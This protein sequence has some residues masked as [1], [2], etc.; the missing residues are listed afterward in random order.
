MTNITSVI[1]ATTLAA[2]LM[3]TAAP[4]TRAAEP[5]FA[6]TGLA[7]DAQRYE[8]QIKV[9]IKTAKKSP[10]EHTADAVKAMAGPAADPRAAIASY[11]QTVIA[12]PTDADAWTGLALALL[13]IKPDTFVNS[14][15]SE[16]PLNASAA[17][18]IGYERAK[19]PAQKAQALVVLHEALKRRQLWRP[20]IEALKISLTLKDD[21]AVRAS[22][23]TLIAEKGFRLLDYKTDAD[24]AQPR[25]CMQFSE[26]LATGQIEF[27]KFVGV[28]GKAPQSVSVEGRQLCLDGLAHGKR[29]QVQV[30]QGLPS[31]VEE[32]LLKSSDLTVYVRD[33]NPS[34]RATGRAY[35]LPR[36]GQQGLP[37]VSVN[38]DAL[39]VEVYRVGD[40]G[41]AQQLQDGDFQRRL[42]NADIDSLKEK[43]GA[44]V[45][46]GEMAVTRKLNEDVTTAFP[47]AEAIGAL[48][49]GAYVLAAHVLPKKSDDNNHQ[50]IQW[51]IVSDLGLTVFSGDDGVHGFVRS[52]A[53]AG[54]VAGATIKLVARNNEILGT[55]KTDGNGY[56]RFDAGLKRGEGGLAPAMLTAESTD[57]DYAFLDL[58]TGAF[59][60]TDR[61]VKGRE[62][63]GPVDAY[64][65]AERGVYR[66]GETV[67]LTTLVR[68][69][70][71]KAATLPVTAIVTRPDGVEHRRSTL[72]DQG[73]G[74]RTQSLQLAAQAMSGTWRVKIH[75]DVKADRVAEVAF[76]VEDFLP[77]R[78]DLTLSAPTPRLT[79]DAPASIDIAGRYLYGPPAA[80][81]A[82][83]G[84]IVVK[85]STRDLEGLAGYRFGLVDEKINPVRK[86]LEELPV[87]GKDGKAKLAITLPPIDKTARSLEADVLIRLRESGGRTIERTLT[88][89]VDLKQ[90]RIGIKPLFANGVIAEGDNATF[91]VVL[92]GGDGK[93]VA[94]KNLK[95]ELLRIDQRYQWFNRDGE[96]TYDVQNSSR[97]I[98]SGSVDA[99]A[100]APGRIATRV[101]WGRYR[102]EVSSADGQGTISSTA[103][104][105]GFWAEEAADSPE[106]LDVALDKASYKPGDVARVK[107]TSRMAGKAMVAV[108]SAGLQ[109]IKEIDV[110]AG[111]AEFTVPVSDT[112]G[113]GAYVTVTLYRPMDTE[114]KRM[115]GRA[116]GLK[117]IGVEQDARTLKVALAIPDKVGSG[118]DVKVPVGIAGLKAGEQA[119]VV[120]TAVDVGILNLT[121]FEAPKPEGWFY[122][123]RRLAFEI[124]DFYSRLIDG[125]RAERGKLRSG[126]DG[127]AA[128]MSMSGS[129]PVDAIVSL[130]SGIVTVGAD[131]KADVAFKLPDFNGTV[132]ISAVAWS[133]DRVG[134]TTKDLLV[135]DTVALTV[136]GPRFLTLGDEARLQLD[137]HNIEG[138]AAPYKL[139]VSRL[140]DGR[141]LQ[142]KSLDLKA[143]EKKADT[144]TLKPDDVGRMELAV[145]VTGPGGIAV[146]R[147]LS[148]EVKPP[149]GDIKRVTVSSLK[150]KGGKLTLS[151]DL[152][153]DLIPS[154]TKVTLN[155]GPTAGLD[156][157]G[158]M[159]E[160]D[161]YPYGC[162]EQTT[163]RA[164]PLVYLNDVAKQIGIAGDTEIR[165]RVQKAVERVLEM[166][167][168]SGAFGIWGPA[169]GDIWLT[170]YVTDFLTRA[171][172]AKYTVAPRAYAQ[173]LDR[174]ANFV[175]IAQD[176]E[177]GGETR[178]YALYVLARAGRAPMADLRYDVDTRLERFATP[179]AQAQL[180]AALAQ[181]GDKARAEKAFAA[182][183]KAFDGKDNGLTRRDYGS[184]LRDGAAIVTLAA[185]S[186][187]VTSEVPRLVDV[188]AKAYAS[189]TYTS[190]QEQA[191]MLLAA[192]A[193]ADQAGDTTLSVN[194][195]S[196][197]GQLL[198]AMKGAELRDGQLT[199]VNDGDAPVNAFVAVFGAALTPEPAISKGF[200]IERSYFTLDGKKVDLASAA[201]GKSTL[202]QNDRLVVV[203]K[204]DTKETGGRILLVDR[205]P[206]G[207][208]IENPR[209][210]DSGEVKTLDWLKTTV[211]PEHTDFRD[212]RFVAAFDFFG[213]ENG[214]RRRGGDDEAKPAASSAT[215]AYIVRAVT[216]GSFIHPAATVEDMYRPER[217]AR[218]A[219]GRLDV[220]GK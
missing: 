87:T 18:W 106:M 34:V 22:Y 84:E 161:R 185:E 190:T 30:R 9:A 47:V 29:Y 86:P 136:S 15:R 219:A 73:Q 72:A 95:W 58:A 187:A 130:Y 216:P 105:A 132:R 199:I 53:T 19:A 104:N 191:W 67:N 168:A 68:D 12:A 66:P 213:S 176:F 211:A 186:R 214:R 17:A 83:E 142:A 10:R 189:R 46:S 209:L 112:W 25:L 45:Y 162:A 200:T 129:P 184:G 124:R 102:L 11:S 82:I 157:A 137:V 169:D 1:R 208:E 171:R 128:G 49:P 64:I 7:K 35:V 70:A 91:D 215:V 79:V 94:A 159:A 74:G 125:M 60:L 48:K 4:V 98:G 23:D 71:G 85:P 100:G 108:L 165:E 62:A 122:G 193:L 120:L 31:A 8:T 89:P 179:L 52:L 78:L 192:K 99:D 16:V 145:S 127:S 69:R 80:D 163:S 50:A 5:N 178:A 198:R 188:V 33:R 44:K 75:T 166:Q 210:V 217:H 77:E 151:P 160:L 111:G 96:W 59:D 172:E 37:V 13:A 32:G 175:A 88:L 156:I 150:P 153:A 42:N 152:V 135:R 220:A 138:P 57:G 202:K 36:T 20:A 123:Q 143:L 2:A 148:I 21:I 183:L 147:Q 139:S 205:L 174:L 203:L 51:F 24:A 55:A 180:G 115:P 110:K 43:T 114:Q 144:L 119:H 121:R 131:G 76:L 206:A 101:E 97:R 90:P 201:G 170:S 149:A 140:A 194:G 40:R 54:S 164:L 133:G 61:G 93:P 63:P 197:K 6:A 39:G 26:R 181:V 116:L 212:D 167:D 38:A 195:Q 173:A 155:V 107:V 117:W 41:L 196:M 109:S 3:M 218:T 92:A 113:A 177:K 103:F 65:F 81:L 14:E 154:R 126:G 182:A 204:V 56:V 146:K 141:S 207:L 118:A 134:S 28:D 27:A 158:I